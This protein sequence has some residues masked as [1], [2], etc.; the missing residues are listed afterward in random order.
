VV[1]SCRVRGRKRGRFGGVSLGG[2]GGRRVDI[3]PPILRF[4]EEIYEV[5]CVRRGALRYYTSVWML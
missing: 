3:I 1:M 2:D 4:F 5:N